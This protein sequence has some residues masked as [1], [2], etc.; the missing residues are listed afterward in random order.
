VKCKSDQLFR[1]YI[2]I[3]EEHNRHTMHQINRTFFPEAIDDLSVIIRDIGIEHGHSIVVGVK[4]CGCKSLTRL[5]LYAVPPEYFQVSISSAYGWIE[6]CEDL[7]QLSTQCG[8]Q[9]QSTAFVMHEGQ[10]LFPLQIEDLPN[11]V[12]HGDV[13]LFFS[14]EEIQAIKLEVQRVEFKLYNNYYAFSCSACTVISTPSSSCHHPA[15]STA[16]SASVVG[17]SAGIDRGGEPLQHCC[18]A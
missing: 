4:S 10:I 13:P 6:L 11:L 3:L 14:S 5:A 18:A 16:T 12:T 9:H 2:D 7:K 15:Q 17:P 1:I 8:L